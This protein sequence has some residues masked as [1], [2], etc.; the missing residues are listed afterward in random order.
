[1]ASSDLKCSFI[2]WKKTLPRQCITSKTTIHNNMQIVFIVVVVL[3]NA[4]SLPWVHLIGPVLFSDPPSA[5]T[6]HIMARHWKHKSEMTKYHSQGHGWRLFR[7]R[8]V[9]LSASANAVSTEQI[10][11]T[12]MR[13]IGDRNIWYFNIPR[14]SVVSHMRGIC[15]MFVASY[16]KWEEKKGNIKLLLPYTALNGLCS[17]FFHLVLLRAYNV[18]GRC[19]NQLIYSGWWPPRNIEWAAASSMCERKLWGGIVCTTYHQAA[20]VA[21]QKWQMGN[22]TGRKIAKWMSMHL[23]AHHHHHSRLRWWPKPL[24]LHSSSES[25]DRAAA[26]PK[27]NQTV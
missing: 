11:H 5:P 12:N 9:A 16:L 10:S 21:K 22:G 20:A 23:R 1:M 6:G 15:E 4:L 18:F 7:S 14:R 24:Q 27:S 8:F 26:G 19:L 3:A 17:R 13:R 2:C 25:S